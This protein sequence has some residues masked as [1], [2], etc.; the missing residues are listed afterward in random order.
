MTSALPP[1]KSRGRAPDAP[2]GLP[3]IAEARR[4][5]GKLARIPGKFWVA[6]VVM[7]AS[8]LVLWWKI[9]ADQ[10]Q[11]LRNGLLVRQR[12]VAEE[13]RPQWEPLRD[14]AEKWIG[15]C[16]ATDKDVVDPTIRGEWD[17]RR[18]DGLY[19]RLGLQ[20]AATPEDVR[21]AV[22][23]SMHD[24]FTACL[25]LGNNPSPV[26]GAECETTRNCGPREFCNEFKRC[27]EH[28]QPYNLSLAYRTMRVLTPEWV[29]T[30]QDETAKLALRGAIG[31][32]DDAVQFD[33]PVAVDLLARAKYFMAVV[34]EPAEGAD[35]PEPSTRGIPS[36]AHMARVCVWR[37]EDQKK[38]LA[39]RREAAG[40]LEGPGAPTDPK[41]RRAQQMQV[42]SCALAMAVRSAIGDTKGELPGPPN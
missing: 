21:T 17:F 12:E 14:R 35:V 1:E 2:R 39:I 26:T 31:T 3:S 22:D 24:A 15:E 41:I 29:Q 36:G 11:E 10:V 42:N 9:D 6:A 20:R 30:V 5:R 19:V 33:I 25:W 40:A 23:E 8:S 13:L 32:F 4:T 7:L 27:A 28:S 38:M 16:A 34:D 18:M 37:L